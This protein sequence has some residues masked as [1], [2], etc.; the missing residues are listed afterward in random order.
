[1]QTETITINAD[2]IEISLKLDK[3]IGGKYRIAYLPSLN[4][5]AAHMTSMSEAKNKLNNAIE[6]FFKM[7]NKKEGQL[8]AKLLKLK[9]KETENGYIFEQR[10]E[11]KEIFSKIIK[12]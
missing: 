10:K 1:M 6:L 2:S 9:W 11:I 12:I 3:F 8:Q 4:L 5:S 7:N